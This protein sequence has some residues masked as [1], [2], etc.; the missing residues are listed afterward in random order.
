MPVLK[1]DNVAAVLRKGA[2]AR[3]AD[4]LPARFAVGQTVH[5]LNINPPTHTRIPRYVR[6]RR[7]VVHSD[8]GVFIF[9][10]AHARGETVPERLYSVRFSSEELWGPQGSPGGAV[11]VDL[12]ESYLASAT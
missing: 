8:H 1:A 9:A 7:G 10:D 11:Y 2:S 4:P 5:A 12:F 6:G 3:L